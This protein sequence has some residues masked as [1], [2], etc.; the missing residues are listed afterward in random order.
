MVLVSCTVGIDSL[1]RWMLLISSLP[2]WRILQKTPSSSP[3]LGSI[4]DQHEIA[5]VT[6]AGLTFKRVRTSA[7]SLWAAGRHVLRKSQ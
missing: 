4:R 1:E 7:S 2:C 6:V 5:E 3:P